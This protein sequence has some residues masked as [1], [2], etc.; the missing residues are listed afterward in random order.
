MLSAR[1]RELLKISTE[2]E[3]NQTVLRI[4]GKLIHPWTKELEKA[5]QSFADTLGAKKLLLDIR[6]TTFADQNG[7]ALLG[8]IVR[9]ANAVLVADSPLTRHFAEKVRQFE[10]DDEGENNERM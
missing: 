6:G 10:I 4:E 1:G 7:I 2:H 8:K 9:T 5:W 3:K